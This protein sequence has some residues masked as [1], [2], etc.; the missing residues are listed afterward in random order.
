VILSPGERL[1]VDLAM[2]A[3]GA[4]RTSSPAEDLPQRNF[5]TETEIRERE[6]E[7]ILRVLAA[8]K[9]RISGTDGAAERLGVKPSTLAYRMKVFGIEKPRGGF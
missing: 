6:K 5:M 4:T 8:S 3:A 2:P 9:W 7:N 1:R